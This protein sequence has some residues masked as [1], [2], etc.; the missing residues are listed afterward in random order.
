MFEHTNILVAHEQIISSE[1]QTNKQIDVCDWCNKAGLGIEDLLYCTFIHTASKVN[2][3]NKV[4]S[5]IGVKVQ[6]SKV[7]VNWNLPDTSIQNGMD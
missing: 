4:T 3:L 6:E 1:K 2:T 7:K 5:H